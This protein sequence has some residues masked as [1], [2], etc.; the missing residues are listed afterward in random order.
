VT[1]HLVACQRR[2]LSVT[3]DHAALHIAWTRRLVEARGWQYEV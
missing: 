3:N 2:E 1:S